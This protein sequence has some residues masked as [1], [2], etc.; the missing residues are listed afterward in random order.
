[1]AETGKG[2]VPLGKLPIA[3]LA[4]VD[5]ETFLSRKMHLSI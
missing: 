3:V 2:D 4:G 1:L 5:I